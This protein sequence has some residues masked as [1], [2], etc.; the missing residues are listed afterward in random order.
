MPNDL[1]VEVRGELIFIS[2]LGTCHLHKV[3]RSARARSDKFQCDAGSRA[4]R[5]ALGGRQRQG[6]R[7]GVDKVTVRS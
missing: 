5:P 1:Q 6:A 4:A 3:R 7:V 2:Q